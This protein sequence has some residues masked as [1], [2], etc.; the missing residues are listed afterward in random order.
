MDEVNR[1]RNVK[2]IDL[3]ATNGK[4]L[5]FVD[6]GFCGYRESRGGTELRLRLE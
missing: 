1:T 5:P 4:K 3:I 6:V 2:Q